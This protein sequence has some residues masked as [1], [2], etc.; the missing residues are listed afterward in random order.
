MAA[1]LPARLTRMRSVVEQQIA[2]VVG[3]ALVG[4]VGIDVEARG[5]TLLLKAAE[6]TAAAHAVADPVVE[7]ADAGAGQVSLDGV[8][9]PSVVRH[10]S[11]VPPFAVDV[12]L[13]AVD[14]V[15]G[16]LQVAERRLDLLHVGE[17]VEAHDVEPEAVHLVGPRPGDEG[18]HHEL[19]HHG[20]LG[21]GVRAA[22]TVL[23]SAVGVEPVVVARH[24]PVEDRVVGLARR[25]GVVEDHVHDD[26]ETR[27]G[28]ALHHFAEVEDALRTVGLRRVAALRH[29]V[30]EG[31]VPPVVTV[32]SPDGADGGLLLVGVRGVG[33]Q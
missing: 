25:E 8:H 13:R 24:D 6:R 27:I 19:L 17:H 30:V 10:L 20:V 21:S 31:V 4:R 14:V 23:D 28:E 3:A 18:V 1:R 5:E 12:D 7:A 16:R 29:H 9:A 26:P 22:G 32:V 33:C 2:L 15:L 11:E